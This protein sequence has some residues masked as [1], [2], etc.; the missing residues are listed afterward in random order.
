MVES[1]R[2][3]FQH[4]NEARKVLVL[5]GPTASGK[6]HLSTLIAPI[7]DAEIISADSRQIYK[8]LDIGTAKPTASERSVALHHFV[9]ALDPKQDFNA[10]EFG[11]QGRKVIDDIFS[12]GKTPMVVGGSGL[13]LRGLIDGFFDGPGADPE[14]REDLYGKLREGGP[15]RLLEELRRVDPEGASGMLPSNTRRIIRALE[16]H[17]ITGKPISE[18]QKEKIILSFAPVMVGLIW[19]RK[20][21]YR[22]IEE[23]VDRMIAEGL[24]EEVRLLKA[25]G[26]SH[27]LNSLQTTGY[28]EVFAFLEG[29]ISRQEMIGLIKRNTRRYAKR[30]LT[31]FRADLRIRWF[32]VHSEAQFGTIA[33]EMIN[34]YRTALAEGCA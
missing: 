26:Y 14:I 34:H 31:W 27:Q 30:Q 3:G 32:T 11:K 5:L 17:R 12:R 21:L 13:Y 10:G 33:N 16:I 23:R 18:L 24:I 7:L 28:V 2:K 4:S 19:E 15:E 1:E 22:R 25:R 8:Y 29:K 20:A 9:D 6:T